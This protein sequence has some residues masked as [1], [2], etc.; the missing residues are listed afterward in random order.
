MFFSPLYFVFALPP[1]FLMIYAQL[2]VKSAYGKYSKIANQK[3]LTGFKTAQMLLRANGLERVS[4]QAQDE[5]G[6]GIEATEGTLSDHYDPRTKVLRLSRRVGEGASVASLGIVAH[7]VGHA[8]QDHTGYFFFQAR[9]RLVPVANLG[10]TLGYILFFLGFLIGL[11]GLVWL[12]IILFSAAVLFTL[13]TLPVELDASSRA[14]VM[15]QSQGLVTAEEYQG[16]S[17][18]L[19]AAALTYLASMLQAVSNLLYYILLAMGMG[20]RED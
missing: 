2:K 6:V 13:I 19:S 16:A 15:L 20:K 11:T 12:G 9:S 18:V 14:R 10:S 5:K 1:L 17:A 8:V 7:E 4:R 3:G